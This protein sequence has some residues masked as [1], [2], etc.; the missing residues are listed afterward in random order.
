MA[1]ITSSDQLLDIRQSLHAL[2]QPLAILTGLVD[3][4]LLDV[5]EDDPKVQ[6]L[7]LI[8]EQLGKIRQIVLEIRLLVRDASGEPGRLEPMAHP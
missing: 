8:S 5:E 4:L 7:R 1:V 3:L 2:A 6:D